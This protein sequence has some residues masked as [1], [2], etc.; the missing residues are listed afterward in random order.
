MRLTFLRS[1]LIYLLLAVPLSFGPLRLYW[2]LFPGTEL[3]SLAVFLALRRLS[4][5]REQTD[6]AHG[7]PVLHALIRESGQQFSDLLAQVED[8]CGGQEASVTQS[9]LVS[10]AV[11]EMC[12]AIFRH[13]RIGQ[14]FYIQI[15]LFR[16]ED[17]LFEL[18]IRDSG[19]P[20]DPFSLRMGRIDEMENEDEAMDSMGIYLVKQ[21]AKECSYRHYQGFNTLIVRI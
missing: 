4:A 1:F 20:F 19:S 21:E 7:S 18:H 6:E 14:D 8:F 11:E 13:A 3:L 12:A 15:T 9:M 5:R 16:G 17:D 10:M 2:L